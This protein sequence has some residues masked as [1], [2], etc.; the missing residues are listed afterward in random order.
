MLRIVAFIVLGIAL[1]TIV[2]ADRHVRYTAAFESGKFLR[3]GGDTDSFFVRTLPDPQVGKEVIATGSGGGDEFS[4]W[5]SRVVKQVTVGGDVVRPRN[6]KYFAQQVIHYDKDYTGLNS[7]KEK[8]RTELGVGHD[9]NRIDFDT[10]TY[11]G[12]SIFIPE[13]FEHETGI[14]GERGAISVLP[15]NSDSSAS[16]FRL[17][18]YVP[19]GENEAHWYLNYTINPNSVTEKGWKRLDLGPVNRDKGKWTDFIIRFRSN[20]FSVKTNPAKKGI[21]NAYDRV[22]EG[23]KGILQVWKAEGSPDINGNRKMVNKLDL[24]NTP[25]G[26]VPGETQGKTKLGFSMRIYKYSW[27]RVDGS[28]VK[29]PIMMGVDEI[30]FGEALRNGTVYSDVHPTQQPCTER[31]PDGGKQVSNST[32]MPPSNLIAN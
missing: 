24:V 27:Q 32:P 16:F 29:G 11:L 14:S 31:C 26:N 25:V 3:N 9:S 10:E 20:P 30:R 21:A 4:S 18:I 1:P 7:G 6:G 28:S 23:N 8:P 22:Y 17:L 15:M 19:K 12:F 13:N 2:Q 5:D